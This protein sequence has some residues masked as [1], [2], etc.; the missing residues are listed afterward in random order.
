MKKDRTV[1]AGLLACVVM[2]L[3]ATLVFKIYQTDALKEQTMETGKKYQEIFGENVYIFRPEDE[4]EKVQEILDTLWSSQETDQF[5]AKRYAVYFMPGTYE[6][7]EV[8]VGYYMQVAG[9]GLLPSD[10]SVSSIRCNAGWLGD[11]ENHNATCNFWR[12]VENITVDGDMMWAVSQATFLR[13]MNING[14]LKLHDE[15]GWASGGFLADSRVENLIDSGT[16]QQWLTRNSN[17]GMWMGQNWNMVF[18]GNEEG[19][20]PKGTWPGTKYTTVEKTPLIQEKPFL[21]CTEE[22]FG[23]FVPALR[24]ECM[25]TSWQE[26]QQGKWISLEQFYVAKADTDTAESINRALEEGKHLLLTPGI[27][28]L[29][30]PIVISRPDTVILGMGLATLRPVNGNI[31]M[32]TADAEGIVIAGILFDAGEKESD[33]LLQI[34]EES[35]HCRHE[36][37]P[38]VLSDLFFR[39]GGAE[40]NNTAV[41]SCVEINANDVI[42]DNFWVWRADHGNGVGWEKNTAPNGIVINGDYVTFYAL[43]VEHFQEYQTVWNGEYGRTYFYQCEIPYDVPSQADWMS[44]DNTVNGYAS[45]YV[46]GY[47]THHEAWGLG[48]YSYHRDAVVDLDRACEVPEG[49]EVK[50]HNVCVVMITGNPGISHIIND[51]GNAAVSPGQREIIREYA[52]GTIIKEW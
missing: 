28:D 1:Q 21:T 41:N 49:E 12:G 22:G 5:G 7:I 20:A 47:V 50:I 39:V 10:T 48:I 51:L 6:G 17:F 11:E 52:G 36:R 27:Y 18:V 14:S 37:A 38:I 44:H 29:E 30:E 31:A 25:G 32:Q 43:M 33:T 24:K 19:A 26:G 2:A 8:N 34:G 23:V 16:Q 3:T 40:E 42:G 4:P 46:D 13:R 45:Y 9:L 15:Y 35:I